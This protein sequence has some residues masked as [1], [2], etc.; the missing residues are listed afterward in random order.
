MSVRRNIGYGLKMQKLPQA[1]T[2]AIAD[3][4]AEEV[5]LPS[6]PG[7]DAGQRPGKGDAVG[8][9]PRRASRLVG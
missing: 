8:L 7:T 9:P 1:K 5:A 3:R 4:V 6:G 2:M